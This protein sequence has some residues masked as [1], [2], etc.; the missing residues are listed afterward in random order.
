M[1][2]SEPQTAQAAT[3]IRI[4]PAVISGKGTSLTER[5]F[6]PVKTA[7]FMVPEVII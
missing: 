2:R 5:D 1:R 3:L 6:N 7:A 4:D